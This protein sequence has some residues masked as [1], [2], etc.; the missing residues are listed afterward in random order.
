[1]LKT[2]KKASTYVQKDGSDLRSALEELQYNVY[3]T[4]F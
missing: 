1:M 3:L 2:K 4:F